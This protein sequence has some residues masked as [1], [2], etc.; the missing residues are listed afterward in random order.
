MG[1]S[2]STI[3][4]MSLGCHSKII[5]LGEIM[6]FVRR[7]N[8][9]V[10]LKSMCSCG[11]IGY[12]CDFWSQAYE[13][14]KSE[15]NADAAYL[16]ILDFFF[17][18]YGN[19]TILV[20]SSKNSYK[21]LKSVAQKYN[22]KIIYLTRDFRSWAFSRFLSQKKIFF[23]YVLR[24][25]IENLKLELRF[26]SMNLSYFRLGY[27]EF[28]L[29]PEF[30]LKKISDYLQINYEQDMLNPTKTK[31]HIIAGNIVRADKLKKNKIIYDARWFTSQRVVYWGAFFGFLNRFN[32]KRVYSNIL[33]KKLK[34][35]EFYLFSS[36][37][38]KQTEKKYN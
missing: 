3:L 27:E 37:R 11:K 19:D 36:S 21:I 13:K 20:D 25:F 17:D 22:L 5:G 23:F 15:K 10:D 9:A 30:I 31:S 35:S 14:I 24:W 18:K 8:K 2:G 33:S 26:K 16:K 38:R 34:S 12:N 28:A 29:Y 7:K 32:K 4:D 1:H 6:T